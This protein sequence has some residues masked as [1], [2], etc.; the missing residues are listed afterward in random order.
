M[1]V[2]D[3]CLFQ[4]RDGLLYRSFP[5]ARLADLDAADA[6]IGA[7]TSFEKVLRRQE[8]RG[9]GDWARADEFWLMSRPLARWFLRRIEEWHRPWEVLGALLDREG[10]PRAFTSWVD[11]LREHRELEDEDITLVGLCL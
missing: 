10:A 9:G 4:V 3:C 11:E 7:R 2:G 6:R 8:A 5:C 1:G